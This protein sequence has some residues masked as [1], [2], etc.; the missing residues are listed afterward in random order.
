MNSLTLS[1]HLTELRQRILKILLILFVGFC[2]CY[3]FS[4]EIL[5]LFTQ[6]IKPYLLATKGKL[7]FISPF[8]KFFSYL[9]ASL[10]AGLVVSCPFWLYQ[11]WQFIAPGLYKNEKKWSLIFVS[12]SVCLFVSGILFVYF[13][14]YPFSFRFL[15]N[16]GGEEIPYIS[17]K[18]YL[19]FFLRTAFA[20]GLVFL[21]PLVLLALLKFN[22]L[23]VA[24]LKK[25][26]P[27]AVVL[28]ALVSAMVTPPDVFSMFFMM[29]PLYL[30]FEIS[31][32]LGHQLK[33]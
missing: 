28:I 10:F 4:Q 23:T 32:W 18:P 25:A 16:F 29:A 19:S 12:L 30:L 15:F 2:A 6:P 33:T 31:L 26:R 17:I 1:D 9:W 22:I 27:Y 5:S 7:I 20:F 14:V 8:E 13:V 3:F 24:E 11:V 21:S